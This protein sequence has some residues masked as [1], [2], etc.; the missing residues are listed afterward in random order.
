[1]MGRYLHARQFKRA[2]AGCAPVAEKDPS[3]RRVPRTISVGETFTGAERMRG[4]DLV[5]SLDR[6]R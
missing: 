2:R 4:N 5:W 3:K 1:M 6:K